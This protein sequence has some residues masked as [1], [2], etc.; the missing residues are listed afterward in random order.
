MFPQLRHI[1]SMAKPLSQHRLEEN[2]LTSLPQQLRGRG[3]GF[4]P[5]ARFERR[6]G[7]FVDDGWDSL[8]ALPRLLTTV[9]E[10][11]P[12]TIITHNDSP[13]VGFDRSI[14]PYRGCEHGCIYCYARP[15]HAH[16]GLSPGLDFESKLFAKPEAA[17]LL[18]AELS[19]PGYRPRTIMLGVNT[20]AYQ[21]LERRYRITRGLLEVM[22]EFRHPVG[23]ITKSALITRDIDILKALAAQGL[24]KAA[25]SL[26]TLDAKLARAMEPRAATPARRLDAIRQ[27]ATAGIPVTVMMAPVVPGLTDHEI[28]RLLQAAQAAGASEAGYILMRLPHE[29]KDLFRD[30]LAR[31]KPDRAARVM[32]LVR[33]TRG[34]RDN[35]PEFGSR[36]VG[37]GP[38]AWQVGRRFQLACERLGLNRDRFRLNDTLFRTPPRPGDQL[39]LW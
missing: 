2:S 21:P 37:S 31:E 29:V 13:D 16:M 39:T 11:T 34:G 4:N 10:E 7:Q 12:R 17:A 8:A 19:A 27:L 9:T 6:H 15:Y 33:D 22:L 23:V 36:M 3:A 14:N 28:E 32:A 26:T 38:Y 25:I 35:D 30:W 18:R 1:A 20:D 24:V 5:A